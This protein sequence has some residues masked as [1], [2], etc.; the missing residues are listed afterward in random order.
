MAAKRAYLGLG[1][2]L[3][4]RQENLRL[5]REKLAAGD[6]TILRESLVYET[7]PMYVAGQPWF[8]NQVLEIE[9]ALFPRQL[10][11]RCQAIERELGRPPNTHNQPRKLDIDILLY[12][13]TVME[14]PELQ[15]PHPRI[16]ERRFVL[17]PLC[18]LSPELRHPQ[19]GKTVREMLAGIPRG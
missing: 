1:S 17:E 13:D 7:A 2:N 14:T 15:I 18:D 16:D 12:G 8:L 5:A 9:T 19:T 3:G 4:D 6:V 11:H 10:L